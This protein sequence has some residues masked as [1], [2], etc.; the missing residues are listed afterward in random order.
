MITLEQACELAL[1]YKKSMCQNPEIK[2]IQ[3]NK[4]SWI[5]T[6]FSKGLSIEENY[7]INPV[8]VDKITKEIKVYHIPS[9][10]DEIQKLRKVK[11]PKTYH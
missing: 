2:M 3:E 1:Q 4:K 9:H 7:G 10:L 5:F 6:I 8:S 11:I